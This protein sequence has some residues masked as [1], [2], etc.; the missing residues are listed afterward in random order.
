MF[1][2]TAWRSSI[3]KDV[4][5]EAVMLSQNS[6]GDTQEEHEQSLDIKK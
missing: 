5:E 1:P 3:R 2:Q 6:T 4:Q